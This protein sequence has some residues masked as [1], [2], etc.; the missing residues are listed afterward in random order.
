[1]SSTVLPQTMETPAAARARATQL[2]WS[3][4]TT[5]LFLILLGAVPY[6]NTLFNGFVYD[7]GY[8]VLKNSYLHSFKYLKQIFGTLAWSFQGTQGLTNYYRP[9]MTFFYLILYQLFGPL[10]YPFHLV[11]VVFNVLVVCCVF[12]VTRRLFANQIISLLAA[13]LFAVHPIHTEVVAWVAAI[14]DLQLSLAVLFAFWCFLRLPEA[15]G[16]RWWMLQAGMGVGFVMALLSKEPG[17]ILPV[18]AMIFEHAYRSDRRDTS[19]KTK[20]SRYSIFWLLLGSYLLFRT[21]FLGAVVPVFQRPRLTWYEVFLTAFSLLGQYIGK[22]FWPLHMSLFYPFRESSHLSDP[23]V[24]AGIAVLTACAVLFVYFWKRAHLVSFGLIWFFLFMA[25]VLNSRWMA[26]NVFAERYLYLPSVGFCW[27]VAW[28]AVSI[29]NHSRSRPKA[30]RLALASAGALLLLLGTIRTVIRNFDWKDDL[31]LYSSTLRVFPNADLIRANLGAAYWN[32]G[33]R[34]TAE[35]HWL[36]A[37]R[38]SPDNVVAMGDLALARKEEKRY[39]EAIALLKRAIELR[40]RYAAVHMTL[41]D[42]YAE[43]NENVLAEQELRKAVELY[44]LNTDSRNRLGALLFKLGRTQEAEEQYLTSL[45][46]MPNGDGYDGLGDLYF[47]QGRREL[48]EQNYRGA[49][50]ENI[51]DHHAHFRLGLIYME[52]GRNAEAIR[53]YN[54][55]LETDP[56]NQE[57]QAALKKLQSLASTPVPSR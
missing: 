30:L 23:R 10:A 38:I 1:M 31:A 29:W 51:Y 11:N 13:A 36:E 55:G 9:M 53:E 42:V 19:W 3:N 35:R 45:R 22:L 17:A 24:I 15:S 41:G 43:L 4:A 52:S 6:L 2:P 26:A 12:W 40:P 32:T 44:P 7:D 39:N 20:L 37:L 47:E 27:I 28:A 54:A 14:S 46:S 34:A 50:S 21:H 5:Y 33:D 49:I 25:P 16:G 8:Q 48:A 18:I 56:N 57:A